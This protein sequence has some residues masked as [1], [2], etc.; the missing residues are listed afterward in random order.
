TI[1]VRFAGVDIETGYDNAF[2]DIADSNST[3][4]TD[5]IS[6]AVA[7]GW[8]N[9]YSDGTFRPDQEITRAESVTIINRIMG[10][11]YDAEYIE[12]NDVNIFSDVTTSHWGYGDILEA[13]VDHTYEEDE[14]GEIWVSVD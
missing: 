7:N 9:G 8:I 13:S 10:R 6:T 3:W 2:N 12:E 4:A 11:V 14:D 1:A 5:Y